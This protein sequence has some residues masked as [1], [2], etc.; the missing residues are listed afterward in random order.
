MRLPSRG[1]SPEVDDAAPI[2]D[3]AWDDFTL[4]FRQRHKQG[5]HVAIVGPNGSGK[6]ILGLELCKLRARRRTTGNHPASVVVL[7]TKRRDSTLD[8]LGWPVLR[9]WPPSVTEPNVIVWPRPK[10]LER[11]A[12]IQRRVMLHVLN[13]IE[14]EGGHTV[15]IDEAAYFETDLP[16]GLGLSTTMDTL[17]R[18][19]R[20]NGITLIATTQRP[21]HVSV[22]MWSEPA[23]LIAFRVDDLNDQKRVAEMSGERYAMLDAVDEL[24]GHQFICVHRP[25]A[26]ERRLFRSMVELR[27]TS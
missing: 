20:S 25:R 18:E 9:E 27:R 7:A 19:S 16:K 10:E 1:K 17:W 12:Q 14:D 4:L 6:S 11:R 26:G 13:K 24:R 15:Y 5:E 21:R 3:L 23:W 8:R 22:S 2:E